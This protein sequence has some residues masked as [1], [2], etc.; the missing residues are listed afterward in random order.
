LDEEVKSWL[1]EAYRVGT[2]EHLSRS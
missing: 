2:Q 1:Q